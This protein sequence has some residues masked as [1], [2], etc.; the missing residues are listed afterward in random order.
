[1][2]TPLAVG[3]TP[4]VAIARNTSRANVQFQNTGNTSLYFFRAPVIPTS[5]N[6]EFMLS[7]T[8]SEVNKATLTTNSTSQ[9][10]VVSSGANGSLAIFETVK[11]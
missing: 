4:I 1:M 2:T 9:F 5:T 3:T 6:Y 11:I 8:G 7:G 10:N